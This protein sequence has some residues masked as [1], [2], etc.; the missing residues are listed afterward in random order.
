MRMI[1]CR[2][3]FFRHDDCNNKSYA[4]KIKKIARSS[5]TFTSQEICQKASRITYRSSTDAK[6]QEFYTLVEELWKLE[7]DPIELIRKMP[8]SSLKDF[9][10][11]SPSWLKDFDV[12][13]K[14]RA[15]QPFGIPAITFVEGPPSSD[16]KIKRGTSVENILLRLTVHENAQTRNRSNFKRAILLAKI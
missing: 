8:R 1:E 16:S 14:Q 11:M 3:Y 7:L 10:E 6:I 9:D 13:Y 4:G 15:S 2:H 12:M 5:E